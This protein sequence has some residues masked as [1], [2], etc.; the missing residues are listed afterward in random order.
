MLSPSASPSQ[1]SRFG[2]GFGYGG[3]E[4]VADVDKPLAFAQVGPGHGALGA[5]VP[6]DADPMWSWNRVHA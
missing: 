6:V 1:P 5:G 2:S 3:V 4:F